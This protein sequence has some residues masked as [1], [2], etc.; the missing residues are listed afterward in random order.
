[1]KSEPISFEKGD[2]VRIVPTKLNRKKLKDLGITKF[3]FE[4]EYVVVSA[5]FNA[6]E[7]FVSLELENGTSSPYISGKLFAKK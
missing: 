7:W 2:H 3:N 6:N 5:Y 1:M 4:K